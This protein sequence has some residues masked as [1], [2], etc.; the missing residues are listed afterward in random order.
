[1]KSLKDFKKHKV[2]IKSIRGGL[3]DKTFT[4]MKGCSNCDYYYD[5]NG[6]GQWGPGEPGNI[7][8]C[9]P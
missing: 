8:P 5:D 3:I 2:E 7:P 4:T 9:Q 6:D 1:M